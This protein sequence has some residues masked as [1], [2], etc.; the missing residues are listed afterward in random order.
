MVKFRI[1]KKYSDEG[2]QLCGTTTDQKDEGFMSWGQAQIL[3][4]KIKCLHCEKGSQDKDQAGQL[5]VSRR[6]IFA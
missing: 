4:T 6:N 2:N 3:K 1:A 5:P